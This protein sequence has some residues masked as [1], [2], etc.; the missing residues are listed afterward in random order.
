[1]TSKEIRKYIDLVEGITLD[2]THFKGGGFGFVGELLPIGDRVITESGAGLSRIW[3]Y[4]RAGIPFVQLTAFRSHLPLSVNKE[5]NH[6]LLQ[7]FRAFG[8]SSIRVLGGWNEVDRETG[9]RTPVEEDSFFIPLSDKSQLTGDE[10]AELAMM[11]S[12]Q[13][14]QN[15]FLYGD[16]KFVYAFCLLNIDI[17]PIGSYETLDTH[18][19]EHGWSRVRGNK[20]KAKI[21]P[22][23]GETIV[24][25]AVGQKWSWSF[26]SDTPSQAVPVGSFVVSKLAGTYMPNPKFAANDTEVPGKVTGETLPRQVRDGFRFKGY[27]RPSGVYQAMIMLR[28]GT[29]V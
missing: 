11:V 5:R 16:G 17:E 1:M 28:K 13:Y 4:I 21:D 15:A 12:R 25:P 3:S 6:Q 2:G 14:D 8:L 7:A 22:K 27:Y 19:M 10:L 20:E 9:L 26:P 29:Y 24:K 23:T 18:K